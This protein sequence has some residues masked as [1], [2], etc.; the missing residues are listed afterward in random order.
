MNTISAVVSRCCRRG[1]SGPVRRR[2]ARSGR[3]TMTGTAVAVA[4]VIAVAASTALADPVTGNGK[5]VTPRASDIVGT[6]DISAS[7]V[8]GQLSVDYNAAHRLSRSVYSWNAL[9]PATGTADGVIT[10]DQGCGSFLR[11]YGLTAQI[12]ALLDDVRVDPFGKAH[13]CYSYATA[14]FPATHPST[15]ADGKVLLLPLANET[16]SWAAPLGGD[17]PKNLTTA[18]LH[19]IF[20][21]SSTNWSDFGG[22]PGVIEP[23]LPAA[24]SA[25]GEIFLAAIHVGIPG[26]CVQYLPLPRGC[27]PKTCE[28]SDAVSRTPAGNPRGAI[29]PVS[30]AAY[31]MLKNNKA[32]PLWWQRNWPWPP[33]WCWYGGS[34]RP[35]IIT[36]PC[37]ISNTCRPGDVNGVSPTRNGTP[38]P[39]VNT[40][41]PRQFAGTVYA[42]VP[43]DPNTPDHIS[44]SL[45]PVFGP[46]GWVCT[47]NASRRDLLRNGFN[48]VPSPWYRNEH[49]GVAT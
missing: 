24:G 17:A 43:N 35:I 31:L 15:L 25:V 36:P 47:S 27:H 1:A 32:K 12:R 48:P 44:P 19:K 20:A 26:K 4:A 22:K 5:P 7:F 46:K 30:V 23:L 37:V 3:A 18:D 10:P 39:Q 33:P 42:M 16:V 29:M 28:I 38:Y 40:A 41:W 34:G 6:S 21:C 8:L 45:E 9:S 49:C 13:R 14:L 2:S 11:P